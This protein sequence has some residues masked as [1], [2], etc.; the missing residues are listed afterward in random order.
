MLEFV[1]MSWPAVLVDDDVHSARLLV[2]TFSEREPNLPKWLGDARRGL[3]VLTRQFDEDRANWPN[4]IIVDLKVNSSATLDFIASIAP[5]ANACGSL[6][7]A[8]SFTL[9]RPVRD[10]LHAA[11]AAAVFE[12]Y[13]DLAA[14]RKEVSD[15]INF[16][17]RNQ[18]LDLVGT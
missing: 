10:A 12:R 16:W 18:R 5:M 11:G 4:L 1:Q 7:V 8:F 17:A 15:I 3:R 14:Y 9:D 13:G 6:V 2:R